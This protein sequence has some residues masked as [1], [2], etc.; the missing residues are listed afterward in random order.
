MRLSDS[1][2]SRELFCASTCF[3]FLFWRH[4]LDA[5]LLRSRMRRYLATLRLPEEEVEGTAEGGA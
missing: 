5:S 3:L 4:L 2:P 1:I